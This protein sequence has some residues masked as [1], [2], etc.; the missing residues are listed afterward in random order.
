MRTEAYPGHLKIKEALQLYF[1]KYHFEKG[2]YH[3]KWFKIKMGPVFIPLP[4]TKARVD[5]VKLHD[6]H[7]L[8]TG[9]PATLRGEA[10]IGG[11]EIASGCGKY[12]AA[13]ILNF[14]SL[15]YGLFF[16]PRPV[17][18]AFMQGR[19]CKT[20]LYHNVRY[21]DDLL[22]QT[23]GELRNLLIDDLQK[24]NAHDFFLFLLCCFLIMVASSLLLVLSYLIIV[25]A[26]K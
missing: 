15:F 18:N 25:T 4:N 21:D 9:Y 23:V 20:N 6:I 22:N 8:L 2:G 19:K 24:N 14:G 3:L 13:W 17:Y 5:A 16:F 7:H 26:I 10:E 1:S 11:W 12:Y